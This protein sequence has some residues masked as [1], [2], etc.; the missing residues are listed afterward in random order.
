MRQS[1]ARRLLARG[2]ALRAPPTKRA[3]G[4]EADAD[5]EGPEARFAQSLLT[6]TVGRPWSAASSL[7]KDPSAPRQVKLRPEMMRLAK[8]PSEILFQALEAGYYTT[9]EKQLNI[10]R[11]PSF[12]PDRSPFLLE[13]FF[14]QPRFNIDSDAGDEDTSD[15]ALSDLQ[16]AEKAE[17]EGDD[18]G[19]VHFYRE[20]LLFDD[21][22]EVRQRLAAAE[23]RLLAENP[24]RTWVHEGRDW[25][26]EAEGRGTRKRAVAH[27]VL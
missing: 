12:S 22:P 17:K 13:N 14:D 11:S 18:A 19:A 23:H 9:K 15:D 21:N 6:D 3:A 1:C 7:K 8:D 20:A 10:V 26:A 25:L 27:V 24:V 2:V 5:E 16:K 4:I